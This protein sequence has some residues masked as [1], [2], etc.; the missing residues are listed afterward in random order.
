[1][2]TNQNIDRA[3]EVMALVA[4]RFWHQCQGGDPGDVVAPSPDDLNLTATLAEALAVAG[5]L[6]DPADD[7]FRLLPEMLTEVSESLVWE[8]RP[9]TKPP[10]ART[11]A[12]NSGLAAGWNHALKEL[13][14]RLDIDGPPSRSYR[15]CIKRVPE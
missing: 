1:M 10:T 6:A 2:T 15:D 13:A 3:A 7:K 5:L 11:E 14:R 8:V 4:A 9:S 12:W